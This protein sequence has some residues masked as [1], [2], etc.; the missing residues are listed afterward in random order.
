LDL[1][2]EP[3]DRLAVQ[4]RFDAACILFIEPVAQD[5]FQPPVGHAITGKDSERIIEAL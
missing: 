5:R 4:G 1:V 3:I 2:P